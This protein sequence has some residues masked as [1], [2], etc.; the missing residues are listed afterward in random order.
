[1]IEPFRLPHACESAEIARLLAALSPRQRR[2]LRAYVWQVELGE[3][4]LSVWLAEPKCPV[5]RSTW[6]KYTGENSFQAALKAYRSAGLRWL[7]E[8]DQRSVAGA[9]RRL[10]MAASAAADRLVEQVH[11][12]I[13]GFFR[14]ME[15]WTDEPLPSQE[16][17]QEEMR[18]DPVAGIKRKFFLV[19]Q[20]TLDLQRLVDPRYARLVKRF[21][22]SP[23]KGLSLEIYDSQR[24]AESILDRADMETASK[25]EVD[26]GSRF[27]DALRRAYGASDAADQNG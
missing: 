13:G 18:E 23:T 8:Q 2:V 24:A 11:G 19:R 15:R 25:S 21:S 9:Q 14:V 16:I 5:A 6:Y 7:A 22:D 10:R 4:S 27:E 1:M 12:D 20:A 17:I 3:R 26:L